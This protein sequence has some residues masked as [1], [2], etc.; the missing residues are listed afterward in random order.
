MRAVVGD[1]YQ[2]ADAW[3]IRA[4]QI[5]VALARHHVRLVAAHDRRDPDPRRLGRH[6]RLAAGRG[7]LG[8]VDRDDPDHA[9]YLAHRAREGRGLQGCFVFERAPDF[10]ITVAQVAGV[11]RDA[12]AA[13]DLGD[14]A[15]DVVAG[16]QLEPGLDAVVGDTPGDALAG[17]GI[18]NRAGQHHPAL[19]VGSGLPAIDAVL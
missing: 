7:A 5:A 11:R 16:A 8:H 18:G 10:D 9:A 13:Q 2:G 19:Q 4:D 17:G 14:V 12:L 1:R 6:H 15:G 3:Q